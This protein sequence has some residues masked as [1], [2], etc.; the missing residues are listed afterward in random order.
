MTLDKVHNLRYQL[1]ITLS[2]VGVTFG[3]YFNWLFPNIKWSPVIMAISAM[4]LIG[5]DFFRLR[6]KFDKVLL[7]MILYQ[8][9][10]L[11]YGFLDTKEKMTSQYMSF[12]IY[13]IVLCLL[14]SSMNKNISLNE[15]SK[16][17][18]YTS[19]WSSCLGAYYCSIGYVVGEQAWQQK[20]E[21]DVYAL[22]PFTIASGALMNYFSALLMDKRKKSS[23][24]FIA[25]GIILDVYILFTCEKRTPI[26]VG[27]LGTFIFFYKQGTLNS[28]AFI[29]LLKYLPIL[30]IVTIFSYS[31]FDSFQLKVDSFAENFYYGVLNLLGDN[32]VSD[33]TGSAMERVA[34]RNAA[35][36]YMTLNFTFFNFLFGAGY[37][38][39][40][41]DAPLLEAYIDMG[42]LG[43]LGYF[44]L[45][46]WFPFKSVFIKNLNNV[47]MLAILFTIYSMVSCMN[48]GL[49]YMWNKYVA[50]C[51]LAY[52][53]KNKLVKLS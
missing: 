14:Y 2:V 30:F 29:K 53:L 40:W 5:K 23:F 37:L 12:H 36:N 48:S 33:A 6:F 39:K 7:M 43:F 19:L 38:F 11:T 42:V 27:L 9:L 1:G 10:M 46:I 24:L 26:F 16:T 44:Y 52:V 21:M 28:K 32:S 34:S 31:Y 15:L 41:L 20:Q 18:F 51:L 17:V 47:Q 3:M 50:V 45:V 22:E 13:V 35:L 8:I 49:P 4:L 25:I